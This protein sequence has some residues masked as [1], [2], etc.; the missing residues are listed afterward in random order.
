MV[1]ASDGNYYV[2]NILST[3]KIN[4][5]ASVKQF[6]NLKSWINSL[7]EIVDAGLFAKL[8]NLETGYFA[9]LETDLASAS[10]GAE[11]RSLLGNAEDID[12][13]K[14]L[15]DDP[16]YAFDLGEEGLGN[17]AKWGKSNFFKTVT[18][19]GR[20]LSKNIV[21]SIQSKGKI[22]NLI[23]DKLGM[24]VVELSRYKVF[25]EVAFEVPVTAKTPGGFMKADV[26]LVKY[27]A[28]GRFIEDVIVIENKLS[29]TTAFTDAQK[30]KFTEVKNASDGSKVEFKLK[31]DN[32]KLKLDKGTSLNA[33]KD[34]VLKINDGGTSSV[35]NIT[36]NDVRKIKDL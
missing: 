24:D 16:G 9:K 8:N 12:I 23:A 22:F 28:S 13:W 2:N 11:I 31:F 4:L 19:T 5:L 6:A 35:E 34:K 30:L 33:H 25:E 1:L 18:K 29:A 20:E 26:V 10:N 21:I 7:D 15:K 3:T 32:D 36:A 17:W 27:D 14:I